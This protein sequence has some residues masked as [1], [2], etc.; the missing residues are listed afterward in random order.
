MRNRFI[1]LDYTMYIILIILFYILILKM[2]NTQE[3]FE[4][5][6]KSFIADISKKD[7][8]PQSDILINLIIARYK[9]LLIVSNT[10][11][12]FPSK[13]LFGFGSQFQDI[14]LALVGYANAQLIRSQAMIKK[15]FKKFG[16]GFIDFG[17]G[18]RGVPGSI[19]RS[20][21]ASTKNL[22]K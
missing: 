19:S 22:K 1:Y 2:L 10:L 18:I 5:K 21:R 4:H 16:G 14:F 7:K 20:I 15:I 3:G 9:F 11:I 12:K 8:I 17:N 6:G 13:H